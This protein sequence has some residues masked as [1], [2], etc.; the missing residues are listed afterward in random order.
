MLRMAA[1]RCC[2]RMTVGCSPVSSWRTR[3]SS[4]RT[5][6]C[7]A[8]AAPV[9]SCTGSQTG[10]GRRFASRGRTSTCSTKPSRKMVEPVR[11]HVPAHAGRAVCRSGSRSWRT[12]RRRSPTPFRRASSWLAALQPRSRTSTDVARR[13][14]GPRRRAVPPSGMGPHGVAPLIAPARSRRQRRVRRAIDV[15]GR[16]R[17]AARLLEPSDHDLDR[18]QGRRH[19]ARRR[20]VRCHRAST[21]YGSYLQALST[22]RLLDGTDDAADV[23][24]RALDEQVEARRLAAWRGCR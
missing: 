24:D 1:P 18:R 16:G 5:S 12:A 23:L 15:E 9:R 8:Q 7:S 4:I 10:H 17:R 14:A 13:R 3:S 2:C 21:A 19:P 20:S 6:G 11:L 22:S